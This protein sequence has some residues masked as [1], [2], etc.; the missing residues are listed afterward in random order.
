MASPSQKSPKHKPLGRGLDALLGSGGDGAS[1][2]GVRILSVDQMRPGQFQPRQA[3]DE[4]KID[5]LAASIKENGILQPILVRH[6]GSISGYEIIAGE[7]RWRAAQKAGLHEVPVLVRD[8]D[9]RHA[10]EVALVE[11]LQREDLNALEEAEAY[12]KLVNDFSYTQ[13]ELASHLGISRSHVANTLRL[14]GLPSPLKTLINEGALSAGHGRA[15]L[16]SA[17]PMETAKAIIEKNLS[18]RQAEDMVR[19]Q[20]KDKS[21]G[22]R[23]GGA[24]PA[25][26]T[27]TVALERELTAALGL[28]VT[29][30][31]DGQGGSLTLKYGTLEQLDDIIAKLSG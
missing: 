13:E 21:S 30:D 10:L 26:D 2:S 29:I 6:I 8:L 25:K 16:S 4:A 27:D 20:S 12:Q 5:D 31:F 19:R 17:D 9:D 23:R 18:V 7:R 14:L 3:M 22:A 24:K 1:G 28:K 11:N 15:L